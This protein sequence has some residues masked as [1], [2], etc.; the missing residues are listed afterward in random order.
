MIIQNTTSHQESFGRWVVTNYPITPYYSYTIYFL[1]LLVVLSVLLFKILFHE[2]DIKIY[3]HTIDIVVLCAHVI[4]F[5]L[6]TYKSFT[7]YIDNK[8][9][10]NFTNND[11]EVILIKANWCPACA[12]FLKSNV[13]E[14]VQDQVSNDITFSSYDIATDDP[15][16]IGSVLKIDPSTIKYVPCIFIRTPEGVFA[17]QDNIYDTSSMVKV[18]TSLKNKFTF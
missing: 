8:E 18:L 6:E 5:L 4:V 15:K 13:W 2:N 1:I 11:L 16:I 14:D 3:N 7:E 12:M 10:E 17:Y 9:V